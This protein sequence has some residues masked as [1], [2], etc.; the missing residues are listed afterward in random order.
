MSI[1]YMIINQPGFGTLLKC[2]IPNFGQLT[3]SCQTDWKHRKEHPR[4]TLV[5]YQDLGGVPETGIPNS[6]M[7]LIWGYP[8]FWKPHF[9]AK[10][11]NHNISICCCH[12]SEHLGCW[13]QSLCLFLQLPHFEAWTVGVSNWLWA[14][15]R[16]HIPVRRI[17]G[18]T[19]CDI[20]LAEIRTQSMSQ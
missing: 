9:G 17:V 13:Y 5:R 7:V 3:T 8:D 1:F 14:Q 2:H 11:A 16:S 10:I 6:W 12:I 19:K 4:R 18:I 15:K 20:N